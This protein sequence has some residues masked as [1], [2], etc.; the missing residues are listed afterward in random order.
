MK[1]KDQ[2][3]LEQAYDDIVLAEDVSSKLDKIQLALDIAGI[4]P[5]IGTVADGANTLISSLRAAAAL[6]SKN[7]DEASKHAINAGISAISLIPFADIV[8]LL[9][10]RKL[11]KPALFAAKAIK[12]AGKTAKTQR[13]QDQIF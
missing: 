1:S 7:N 5:T 6:A 8:K 4:E 3:L 10:I 2:I 9:K 11:R 12:L 13:V